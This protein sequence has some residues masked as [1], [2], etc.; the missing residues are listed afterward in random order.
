MTDERVDA[1]IRRLDVPSSPDS[2]FVTSSF[3]ML[4]PRVRAGR[5]QDM[6]RLGRLRRE[7]RL[8]IALAAV[9]SAIRP[10][11]RIVLVG[12]LLMA[13]L[14]ATI[15]LIGALMRTSPIRNGP[16]IV[17]VG[18]EIRAIDVDSGASRPIGLQGETATHVSR[19]P[20][21]RLVAY[22][23]HTP[24]GD[25]LM[26][27]GIDGQDRRRVADE[28]GMTDMGPFDS[29]SP[30]SRYLASGVEVDGSGRILVADAVTGTAR[31]LTR[32]GV[33][34][35]HPLWSPD[36]R[37]IAFT[38][39]LDD[40]SSILAVIRPDGTGIR[41]AGG[42]VGPFQVDGP[43]SWSPD[44]TWIYFGT[45]R[46]IWRANLAAGISVQLT[47]P[48]VFAV[49]PITSPDGTLITY[50]VDTPVGWDLYVANSDG[51]SVRRLLENGRDL[52]W[53][54][55]GRFILVRWTPLDQPGGLAVI[56]PDGG[57]PRVVAPAGQGCPQDNDAVCDIG[58]GQP[59]P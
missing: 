59:R 38:R 30:D 9:P 12:L 35:S 37:W 27:M 44:G 47:D 55:D 25:E 15:V 53:S 28:P 58:W 19:S 26:I 22:W 10:V 29:W 1:L 42:D 33:V 20:D 50:I 23:R 40:G 16:V 13:A 57:E 3:A 14:A 8:A 52:G 31:F 6:S 34:A 54:A 48:E 49:G 2:A 43:D 45:E 4:L 36:G 56:T 24:S 7:I 11:V 39:Q 17:A 18:G 5:A 41:S 32:E 46:S 21:G 51:S